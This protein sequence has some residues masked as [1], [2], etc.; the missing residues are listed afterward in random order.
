MLTLF[1]F[2][3]AFGLPDPSPFVMKSEIQLKMA[4][5]PYKFER[6]APL[7]APK[8]KIP[9]IQAGAHRVGDSTFIRAHIERA[10][11]FD[12]DRGL[13]TVE[14]GLAWA[15][16][17][18]CEDHL[19]FALIHH[20]WMDDEN[21]QKG[22]I[23]F[24]DGAPQG[25]ADAARERVRATLHGHGIGR[26]SHAEIAE[27]GGRSLAA[28]SAFLGDKPWLMGETM[29]G[30]DATAFAMVAGVLTPF[31]TGDLRKQGERHANL[32]AYRDRMMTRFF[33]Q[34]AQKQAA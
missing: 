16:E 8:G 5:V 33:P 18:M 15:M 12:F 31:F 26:H 19:Y 9:Y 22:P 24:F 28:L 4:G 27:L 34:F 17:R 11:G 32:V 14:R 3:P 7:T 6:G 20:R 23:H 29:C 21:W 30:A 1:G 2:G 10:H 13:C 25:A